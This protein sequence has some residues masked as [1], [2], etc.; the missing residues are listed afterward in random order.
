M[1]I[2]VNQRIYSNW[3]VLVSRVSLRDSIDLSVF[4]HVSHSWVPGQGRFLLELLPYTEQRFREDQW[5]LTE[6][7]SALAF[8]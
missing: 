5:K 4:W 7:R 1:G 6:A 8:K 3:L 2:L